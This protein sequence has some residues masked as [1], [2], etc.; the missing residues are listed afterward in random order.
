MASVV[1][2]TQPLG[3]HTAL[4]P[5][6]DP[7]EAR[8]TGKLARDGHYARHVSFPEHTGT[9]LDAPA[10][11]AAGG[12][13]VD[14]IP[15]ER[16]VVP[17][18]VIDVSAECTRDPGYAVSAARIERDEAEHGEL[19]AGWALLVRTGWE[20][21]RADPDR[22]VLDMRFPG[23]APDAA[24][25]AVERGLVGLGIDTL[26]VDP[27]HASDNV[28]VHLI[29]L[30][31]GLWHLEGLINLDVLPPRGAT[32]FVGALKLVDGSGTPARVLAIV[33]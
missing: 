32:L 28:P 33:D 14:D 19:P 22:Y 8:E 27:G 17:C 25:L 26:S 7:F 21:Y 2:L 24:E 29:T 20:A 18:A 13:Y 12:A 23:F 15:H 16:L 31:A 30:P 11:F 9:H 4:W 6:S 3:P 1:D 10:H 5:D